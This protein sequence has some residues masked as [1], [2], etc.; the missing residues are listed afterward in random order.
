MAAGKLRA[1]I[2]TSTLDLGI[3]WGDVDLVIHLGA[4]KGASRFLQRIGRANHRLD[5]PSRGILVPGNRFEVLECRAAQQAAEAGEQDAVLARA[6]GLD[7]LAQHILGMA[8]QAPFDPDALFAEVRSALPYA[9]L[10]RHQFDRTIEFVST[11]G[12]ALKAYDRFAKLKPAGDGRLR[13]AAPRIA[14]QY[15]LNVGTIVDT[16]MLKVRLVSAR[17]SKGRTRQGG[18]VLGEISEGFVE[19]LPPR[20]TFVF[21]GEVLRFEALRDT[22]VFVSRASAEDPMIPSYDGGKFPMSTHL[23]ARVRAMLANPSDWPGL[24]LPVANWLNL[25]TERSIIPAPDDVLVETFPRGGRHFL[26]AYPFE[27]RL[28][29]QTLGMLLTRR[30]DRAG[31]KPL[32]FV[33]S[34]YA[35]SVW[36][37]G[38]ISG[39]IADGRLSL[40]ELFDEDMLGD[41]LDAWLAESSIMK[42]TFRLAAVIAGLIERRH[43]GRVKSGR[44]VTMSTDLIYDVLR[45][46]DPGHLLLEAAWADAATGLLDIRRLGEFLARIKDRIRHQPLTRVSPLS[47][48]I[49]LEIGREQVYGQARDAVLREAADVLIREA[50]GDN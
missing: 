30:L 32:G 8:C 10:T 48:P 36:G 23:A 42:R 43:P 21:A 14:Q 3:D 29:H 7:V 41:D 25:Q 47:V 22:E 31:T 15:R 50:M 49:L 26:V 39:L 37:H 20:A 1:V 17:G 5:E 40:A 28:A 46:H 45:R 2:A 24:P 13:V 33:A 9:G 11:G 18:R 34:D 16:P 4:P 38:D 27:G 12:Y 44:Q 6:G 19:Q 35:L